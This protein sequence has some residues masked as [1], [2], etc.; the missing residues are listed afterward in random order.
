M[1][2]RVTLYRNTMLNHS[3]HN[4]FCVR[5]ASGGSGAAALSLSLALSLAQPQPVRYTGWM[6]TRGFFLLTGWLS[7]LVG[8]IGI[9]VPLLPTVPFVILAAYC[10]ARGSPRL[11]Q[12]LLA[13]P[14]FG[15]H[16]RAWRERGAISRKG[17][18]AALLAFAASAAIAL[19]VAPFPVSM[20]PLAAALIGGTWIWTRQDG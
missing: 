15:H 11:E 6:M 17:K 7:L 3:Q 2:R 1:R 20:I 18:R 14:A 10:F 5:R 9:L 12:W 13:H 4:H 8:G 16:I 19:I